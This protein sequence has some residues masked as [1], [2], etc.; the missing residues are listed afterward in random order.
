MSEIESDTKEAY[1]WWL[2]SS[3]YYPYMKIK[4]ILNTKKDIT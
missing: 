2:I 4:M 3:F 1:G